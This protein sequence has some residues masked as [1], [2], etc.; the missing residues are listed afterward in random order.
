MKLVHHSVSQPDDDYNE[1]DED[2]DDAQNEGDEE[3]M[4]EMNNYAETDYIGGE[5]E[6][7]EDGDF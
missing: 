6:N 4:D 5:E 1:E 7:G 2:D 3:Q